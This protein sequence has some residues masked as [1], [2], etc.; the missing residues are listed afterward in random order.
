VSG[1]NEFPARE[2]LINLGFE[3]LQNTRR[4]AMGDYNLIQETYLVQRQGWSATRR[5][6]SACS[7]FNQLNCSQWQ[8]VR[9]MTY[10][11]A[12]NYDESPKKPASFLFHS[13]NM[14]GIRRDN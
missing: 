10:S 13:R 12:E 8:A 4:G 11:L 7:D 2:D 9:F 3:L 14:L 6:C 1:D 5:G